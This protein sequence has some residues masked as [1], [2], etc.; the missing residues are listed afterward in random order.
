[1]NAYMKALQRARKA[2]ADSFTYTNA[3]GVKKK[4]VREANPAGIH[5]ADV[6]RAEA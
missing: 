6:Y 5:L 1:M 3:A 4:Y 2:G